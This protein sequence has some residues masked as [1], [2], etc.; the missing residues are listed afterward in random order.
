MQKR[1]IKSIIR[2]HRQQNF[3]IVS[4][5]IVD[6]PNLSWKAK[7]LMMYLLAQSDG[8]QFYESEIVTRGKD[9]KDGVA[10]GLIELEKAGYLRRT[11]L[12][13]DKGQY[14]GRE[15]EVFETSCIERIF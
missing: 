7:G 9:G 8:W 4:R 11:W 12:R 14:I 13:G 1:P 10:S 2:H 15:W 5:G 3:V 6:D